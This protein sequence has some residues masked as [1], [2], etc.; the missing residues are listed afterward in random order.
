M[1]LEDALNSETVNSPWPGPNNQPSGGPVWPGQ[2]NQPT[3]PGQPTNPSTLPGQ[4][5]NPVWPGQPSNQ[6]GWPGQ[7]SNQPGWPGQPSNQPGWPGQ[8]SPQPGWPGHPSPQPIVPYDQSLPSGVYDK[9]LITIHAQVKP[10]AKMFTINLSKGNDIALHFN[11]RFN[12]GGKQVIV[13]NSKIGNQWGKEERDLPSFPFSQGQHFELKILCTSNA[14]KV[15]VNKS[16]LLEY[17][18]RIH[19][20]SNIKAISIYNDVI[21][22][23]VNFETLTLS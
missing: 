8:P 10:N 19:D 1:N 2:P 11:P 3:W 15:A 6:P 13:R 17:R 16:H 7:P 23:S 5:S 9:M 12:E 18:H 22:T 20:L 4:P 14:F 21:L